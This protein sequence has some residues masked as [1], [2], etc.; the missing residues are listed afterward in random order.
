MSLPQTTAQV[1]ITC[2]SWQE[3][4]IAGEVNAGNYQWDFEWRFRLPQYPNI[5]S[6]SKCN[7]T[8]FE[9]D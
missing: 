3:G 7:F 2:Q 5:F 8:V 4:Q 6:T 1:R 9:F